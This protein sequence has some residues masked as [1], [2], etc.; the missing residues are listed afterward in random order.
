MLSTHDLHLMARN[1]Q[2]SHSTVIKRFSIK[3]LRRGLITSNWRKVLFN[4]QT[5]ST[6]KKIIVMTK[7]TK[8]YNKYIVAAASLRGPV[9]SAAVAFL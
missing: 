2:K 1:V 5:G 3:L 7:I 8:Q 9:N 6:L 4:S